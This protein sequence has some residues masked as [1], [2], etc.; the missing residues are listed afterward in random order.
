MWARPGRTARGLVL[1]K[2]LLIK[3]ESLAGDWK[4]Y[5]S[6]IDGFDYEPGYIYKLRIREESVENPPADASS[7]K[8]TLIAVE[9]KTPEATR[10]LW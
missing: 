2:C 1:K 3:E 4:Y 6:S 8:W 5:Y 7:L 10:A 9:E